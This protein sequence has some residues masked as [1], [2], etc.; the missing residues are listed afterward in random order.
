LQGIQQR[1][2]SGRLSGPEILRELNR[3]FNRKTFRFESLRGC[4]EQRWADR[5]DSAY[6]TER[7]L[8]MW[9]REVREAEDDD[10][11]YSL[12]VDVLRATGNYCMQMGTL[13]FE[14][15]VDYNA[16]AP[17]IGKAT[18]KDHLPPAIRFDTDAT[19]QPLIPDATNNLIER[20]RKRAISAM[21]KLVRTKDLARSAKP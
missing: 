15:P 11:R 3:L 10:D 4:P 1:R 8:R 12:Y 5:L 13:L 2:G 20:H 6:Q 17:H 9:E 7:V 14:E 18:F 21:D 16:V 19:K